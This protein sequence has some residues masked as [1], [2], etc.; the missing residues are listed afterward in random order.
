M[1]EV[2]KAVPKDI[3]QEFLRG[4]D[5][6]TDAPVA[7]DELTATRAR[8]VD[9]IVGEMPSAHRRFLVSFEEGRPEWSLLDVSGAEELPAVRWQQENLDSLDPKRRAGLVAGLK[10]VLGIDD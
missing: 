4:F 5:G 10:D 7:V 3:G 9:A 6:M 2:L 8:L 1:F